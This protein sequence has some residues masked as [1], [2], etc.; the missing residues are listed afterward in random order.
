MCDDRL[1]RRA[2]D[3]ISKAIAA[4][5]VEATFVDFHAD[6]QVSAMAQRSLQAASGPLIAIG[7]SMGGIVALEMARLAPE[8]I[9][10]LALIDTTSHPDS[11]GPQRLRQ[12]DDVRQGLLER[13]VTEELKPNYLAPCH[14]DDK[15]MLAL[16]RDMAMDLGPEIFITQ[17]EALRTRADYTPLLSQLKMPV[18]LACG[19]HDTLCAPQIHQAMAA[20][21]TD[22]RLHIIANS[23]HILP[24]E[25]PLVLA[26]LLSQFLTTTLG[27]NP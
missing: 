23:G 7:F 4:H 27:A 10:G 2:D 26:R 15:D 13:V 6:A 18:L 11:R 5:G 21:F 17:S 25:Q 22:S 19:E 20:A 8:R 16:L 12:Q 9:V 3:A 1:W 14:R 24:L